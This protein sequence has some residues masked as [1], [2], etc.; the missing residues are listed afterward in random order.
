MVYSFLHLTTYKRKE[1]KKGTILDLQKLE[2]TS[3]SDTVF[4]YSFLS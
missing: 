3:S 2:N 4:K 1:K